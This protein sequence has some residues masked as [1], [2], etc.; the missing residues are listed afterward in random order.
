M[1]RAYNPDYWEAKYT[2]A[3][4]ARNFRMTALGVECI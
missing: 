3:G 4:L 2:M 1:N